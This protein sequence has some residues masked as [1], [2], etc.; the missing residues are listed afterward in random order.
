[1]SKTVSEINE[2]IKN[3]TVRVVRADEMTQIVKQ[4]GPEQAAREVDV[5]TTGTFGAMCSS[6]VFLN[7]GHSDPPIKMTKTFINDVEA[8][9]GL[10]AVDTYLG[11]T[12]PSETKGIGYGGAH[13]IQDLLDGKEVILRAVSYGTDCYPRKEIMRRISLKELNTARLCNPRNG[14][15]RYNAAVNTG[16]KD[17]NTYMGK[18]LAHSGNVTYSG[19]GELSPLMNDPDYRTIGTGTRI[20]L[21]GG[22]GFIIA[23][24]TQH[25]PGNQFGTLMVQGDLKAMSSAFIRAASFPGYGC[26]LYVGMGIPI[27]V[28]DE[29]IAR[30]TGISDR[31]IKTQ[32]IDYSVPSNK[33]PSLGTFS[34]EELKSGSIT[35][36]GKKILTAPLSSF[37]KAREI[38]ETLKQQI[39]NGAFLLTEPVKPLPLSGQ[40]VPLEIRPTQTEDIPAQP[41][42]L[43][44]E[45]EI[46]PVKCI[47]CGFCTTVCPHDVFRL[48]EHWRLT[49]DNGLCV[50][51]GE[52]GNI[53]PVDAIRLP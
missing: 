22:E 4:I 48:D 10:A 5:V 49:A 51:C 8:Y 31:D 6:G 39:L 1:M 14:Y 30:R 46:D 40:P 15:Q 24:G 50:L 41:L 3:K 52:C 26:S 44:S 34:F 33:R 29:D 38:A 47:Q 35:V 45:M 20:F 23:E 19:A 2:R 42:K 27:P 17:L 43:V 11:A 12:Q 18:L 21:G 28:L 16:E 36:N 9:S 32:L 25:S 53:C 13:V 37:I 7:T